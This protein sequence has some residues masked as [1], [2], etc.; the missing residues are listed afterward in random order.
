[1]RIDIEMSSH[2]LGRIS[3]SIVDDPFLFIAV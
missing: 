3:A 1:L 2:E